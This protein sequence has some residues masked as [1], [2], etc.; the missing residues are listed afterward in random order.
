MCF[1]HIYEPL[2]VYLHIYII[3]VFIHLTND[4]PVVK[5]NLPQRLGRIKGRITYLTFFYILFLIWHNYRI[6]PDVYSL[7][8]DQKNPGEN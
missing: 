6:Q 8:G 7:N 2:C 5:C 3:K 1:I 4:N